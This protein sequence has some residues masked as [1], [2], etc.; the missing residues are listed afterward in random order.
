MVMSR[1]KREKR[2][3]A[4]AAAALAQ[5]MV[6]LNIVPNSDEGD[7]DTNLPGSESGEQLFQGPSSGPPLTLLIK[8]FLVGN[9]RPH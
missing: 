9:S 8:P 2:E 1:E 5:Q 7:D 4:A 3:A 6:G